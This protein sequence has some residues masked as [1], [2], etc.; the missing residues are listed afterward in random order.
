MADFLLNYMTF[1][2]SIILLIASVVLLTAG[3]RK[4]SPQMNVA[5]FIVV[6]IL[7]IYFIFIMIMVVTSGNTP[8]SEP[9]P[10]RALIM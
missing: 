1:G 2:V 8:A 6:D 10:I 5:L 7:I 9:T 4:I 3:R